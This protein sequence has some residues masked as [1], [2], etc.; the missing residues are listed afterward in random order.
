VGRGLPAEGLAGAGVEFGGDLE[1]PPA[2]WSV[3]SVV[4][5][6]ITAPRTPF[7]QFHALRAAETIL[8]TLTTDGRAQ[9]RTA[10]EHAQGP[11]RP[12]SLNRERK[13]QVAALLARLDEPPPGRRHP[14]IGSSPSPFMRNP[15]GQQDGE[16]GRG[17][18][19]PDHA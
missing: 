14:N 9:L 3:G 12:V 7:E 18:R 19:Q 16:A 8:D 2:L 5:D 15:D 17:H 11:D 1:Q 10:I 6:A 13:Q 4:T